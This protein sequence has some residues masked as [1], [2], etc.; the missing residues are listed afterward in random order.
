MNIYFGNNEVEKIVFYVKPKTQVIPMLKAEHL[1]IRLSGFRWNE[2][3]K[4]KFPKDVLNV[5][6]VIVGNNRQPDIEVQNFLLNE[7]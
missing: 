2:E 7:N 4:P 3:A 6:Q 5:R 1:K